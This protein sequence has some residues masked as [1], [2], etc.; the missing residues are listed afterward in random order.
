MAHRDCSSS[1]RAVARRSG[2]PR[3][4]RHRRRRRAGPTHA[5]TAN[6]GPWGQIWRRRDAPLVHEAATRILDL[7]DGYPFAVV[8]VPGRPDYGIHLGRFAA[9]ERDRLTLRLGQTSYQPDALSAQPPEPEGLARERVGP[10]QVLSHSGLAGGTQ[11]AEPDHAP[12]DALAQYALGTHASWAA[13]P[14]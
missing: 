4:Q 7:G 13:R 14:G 5:T 11:D 6:C 9:G 1:R 3:R 8:P 2:Q 12:E 10:H